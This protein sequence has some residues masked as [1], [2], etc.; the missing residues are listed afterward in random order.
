LLVVVDQVGLAIE[1]LILILQH[2]QAEE[3]LAGY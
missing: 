3:A 2:G 1:R